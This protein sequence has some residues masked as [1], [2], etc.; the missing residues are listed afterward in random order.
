MSRNASLAF[1]LCAS[2]VN[3]DERPP[4]LEA[5]IAE[6]QDSEVYLNG[7]V[8]FDAGASTGQMWFILSGGT[9]VPM[10]VYPLADG[11][12]SFSGCTYSPTQG[13]KPCPLEGYGWIHFQE[14]LLKIMLHK[15]ELLGPPTAWE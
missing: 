8:G 4:E 11:M 6:L 14:S 1:L 10:M 15:V 2:V 7:F 5:I 12:P 13:G 3:A 9:S